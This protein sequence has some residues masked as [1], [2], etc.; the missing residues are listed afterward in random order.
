[1]SAKS[2]TVEA[3][4]QEETLPTL[5][6]PALNFQPTKLQQFFELTKNSAKKNVK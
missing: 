5:N 1:M 6:S 3:H 2:K 4:T